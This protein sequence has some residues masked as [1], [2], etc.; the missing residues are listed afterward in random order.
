ML[1]ATLCNKSPIFSF[2]AVGVWLIVSM[3]LQW[4]GYDGADQYTFALTLLLQHATVLLLAASSNFVMNRQKIVGVGNYSLLVLSTITLTGL[5]TSLQNTMLMMGVL[6]AV[7]LIHRFGK[8][9][10]RPEA[11]IEEFEVGIISG[12]ALLISP[13][14]LFLLPFS[15]VALNLSKSNRIRDFIAILLGFSFIFFLKILWLL[16][17]DYPLLPLLNLSWEIKFTQVQTLS[18]IQWSIL[19]AYSYWYTRKAL[20]YFQKADQ[21]SIRLRIF[22]RIVILL[23][24]SVFLAVLTQDLHIS[25]I[26]FTLMIMPFFLFLDQLKSSKNRKNWVDDVFILLLLTSTLSI[27]IWNLNA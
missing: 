12:L 23:I 25:A 4:H 22:Y 2:F 13:L 3:A 17:T 9:F 11:S 19:L 8:L 20:F 1:Y 14:F 24:V 16:W 6:L 18:W 26:D 10:N 15:L 5:Q 7:V 21:L 27:H